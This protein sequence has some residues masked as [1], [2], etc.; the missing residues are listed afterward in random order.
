MSILGSLIGGIFANSARKKAEAREDSQLQRLVADA[1]KAGFNPLSALRS[2]TSYAGT[3]TPSLSTA[4]FIADAVDGGVDLVTNKESRERQGE[5]EK[6]ELEIQKQKL[7]DL[8]NQNKVRSD[9]GFSIPNVVKQTTGLHEARNDYSFGTPVNENYNA[10][11]PTGVRRDGNGL[12]FGGNT[13][14]GLDLLGDGFWRT[15]PYYPSTQHVEDNYGDVASWGYGILKGVA[16]GVATG[17][18]WGGRGLEALKSKDEK[19]KKPKS[20]GGSSS[21]R[22]LRKNSLSNEVPDFFAP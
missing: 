11:A 10:D 13:V 5:I 20:K 16:D 8:Q 3:S 1:Q 19:P 22:D 12:T 17:V 4:S 21:R 6:L 14:D 15:N 7:A 9:Y 18:Y 2:G